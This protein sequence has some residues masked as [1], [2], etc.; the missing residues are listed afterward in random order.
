[1][2]SE[3]FYELREDE[4]EEIDGGVGMIGLVVIGAVA[5]AGG[6]VANEIVERST[7]KDIATHVGNALSSVGEKIE[8]I[9]ENWQTN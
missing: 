5:V 7:G 3:I 9:G 6:I 4:I 8:T 1:M 2:E